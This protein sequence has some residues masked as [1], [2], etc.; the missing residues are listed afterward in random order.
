MHTHRFPSTE[1]FKAPWNASRFGQIDYLLINKP[2][3][4]TVKNVE[5][6]PELAFDSDHIPLV[7][8]LEIKL[9][10]KHKKTED[11]APKYFQPTEEQKTNYND[12]I[13]RAIEQH[14]TFTQAFNLD[15]IEE[16]ATLMAT[17]ARKH[18]TKKPQR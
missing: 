9:A 7:A 3:K 17:A 15:T 5:S 11:H 10:K 13:K 12:E 18:F 2:W 1:G 4:N 6:L 16:F 8:D 14:S